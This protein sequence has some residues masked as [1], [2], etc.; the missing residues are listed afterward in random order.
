MSLSKA[1]VREYREL[2]ESGVQVRRNNNIRPNTGSETARHLLIKSLA[3]HIGLEAR[4]RVDSETPVET[5]SGGDSAIDV[6][7]WGHDSRLTYAVEVETSPLP[8]VIESKVDKYV[9]QTAI[10]DMLV[11]NV[12]ECP[13]DMTQA[14][15][16]VASEL[17]LPA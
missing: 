14:Y 2:A 16:W 7:L 5:G 10:D 1:Q 8:K 3:A 9:R 11:L 17:G 6:L 12:A 15:G 4:Y 13:D